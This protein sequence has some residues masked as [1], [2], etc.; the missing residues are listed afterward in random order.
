MGWGIVGVACHLTP[1]P[2]AGLRA[3]RCCRATASA[4]QKEKIDKK[5][6]FT[7]ALVGTHQQICIPYPSD[8]SATLWCVSCDPNE[9][10]K[11]TKTELFHP[12]SGDPEEIYR[13]PLPRSSWW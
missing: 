12:V 7:S 1:S 2:A 3:L 10:W 5:Q 11:T 8:P 9:S 4:L 6:A 13:Q